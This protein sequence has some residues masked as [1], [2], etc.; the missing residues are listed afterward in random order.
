MAIH[1]IDAIVV[2]LEVMRPLEES[3][4]AVLLVESQQIILFHCS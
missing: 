1:D 3:A 4:G 2:S